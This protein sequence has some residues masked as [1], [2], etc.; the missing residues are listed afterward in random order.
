[1]HASARNVAHIDSHA[2]KNTQII[3]NVDKASFNQGKIKINL[4]P[5]F[6]EQESF[7]VLIEL[8]DENNVLSYQYMLI[9][10]HLNSSIV[11]FPNLR[12][13][14]QN[15]FDFSLSNFHKL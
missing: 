9:L 3:V 2:F 12:E 6:Q 1:M 15:M 7:W 8:G 11:S 5:E 10:E 4:Y 14:T 13:Y